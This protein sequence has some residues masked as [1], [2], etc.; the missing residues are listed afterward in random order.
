LDAAAV[1]QAMTRLCDVTV[2]KTLGKA[3]RRAIELFSLSARQRQLCEF[4][5]ELLRQPE[6]GGK[7]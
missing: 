2:A 6:S 3:A 1:S 4:Y 7:L 5:L